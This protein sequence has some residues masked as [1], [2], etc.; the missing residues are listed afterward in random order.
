MDMRF[1]GLDGG[2]GCGVGS[3]KGIDQDKLPFVRRDRQCQFLK[4]FYEALPLKEQ[5][6]CE[7]TNPFFCNA[8]EQ[9]IQV[10][11]LCPRDRILYFQTIRLSW[12]GLQAILG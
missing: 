5:F 6:P 12:K 11:I 7:Q 4:I 8:H 3:K 1:W 2:S 9:Y 10:D